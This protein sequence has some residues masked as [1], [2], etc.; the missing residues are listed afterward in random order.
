MLLVEVA[1]GW[2]VKE[3]MQKKKKKNDDVF[4]ILKLSPYSLPQRK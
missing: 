2:K 3:K 1:E 4:K